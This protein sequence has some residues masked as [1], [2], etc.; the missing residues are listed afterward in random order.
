LVIPDPHLKPW[1]FADA[2]AIMSALIKEEEKHD[3]DQRAAIGAVCLGDWADDFDKQ[4]DFSLYK[5]TFEAGIDF[6]KAFP[7]T[8]FCIGNHDISYVWGRREDGYS[9]NKEIQELVREKMAELK[10]LLEIQGRYG[11]VHCIDNVV[12]SHAGLS[13][14]FYK[15][16]AEDPDLE[17]F[18]NRINTTFGEAELWRKFSPIWARIQKG[19]FQNYAPYVCEKLQVVGHTP[20]KAVQ[21]EK[22][23]NLLSVD[24]FSTQSNGRPMGNVT[25]QRY[26]V[27]D[28]IT[29]EFRFADVI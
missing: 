4:E 2:S 10:N 29:K 13:K 18:I 27:V 14:P 15:R 22:K 25:D 6:M 3:E 5:A 19:W 17:S 28:T 9:D 8:W 21:F 1:M 7:N 26:V 24:V 20:L 23:A 11:F 12:F 16:Y